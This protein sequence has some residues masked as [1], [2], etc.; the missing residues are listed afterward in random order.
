M[1]HL[2]STA[3]NYGAI[4]RAEKNYVAAIWWRRWIRQSEHGIELEVPL[5][6]SRKV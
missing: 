3:L 2:L 6:R 4:V 1:N 5:D